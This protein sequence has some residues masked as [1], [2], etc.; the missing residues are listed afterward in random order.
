[1]TNQKNNRYAKAESA[2]PKSGASKEPAH[3]N[4]LLRGSNVVQGMVWHEIFSEPLCKRRRN[5]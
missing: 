4:R 3:G 2:P 1:M 5:K